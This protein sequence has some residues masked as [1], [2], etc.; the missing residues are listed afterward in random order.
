MGLDM[1]LT[2]K[3]YV[4]NWQHTPEEQKHNVKI[5][6]NGRSIDSSKVMTIEFEEIYWRKANQIH[7]WFVKNI[8]KGIDN[9]AEYYVSSEQLANLLDDILYSLKNKDHA[10]SVLPTSKGFFFGSD[11]YDEDYWHDLQITADELEELLSNNEALED[12][13]YYQ[14][15]W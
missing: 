2:R 13:F 7:E 15:S 3:K 12:D 6:R 4:K 5:S 11:K 9:C 14:S 10:E 1:Y 8:Q